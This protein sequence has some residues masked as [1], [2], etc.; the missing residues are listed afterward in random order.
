MAPLDEILQETGMEYGSITPVGLPNSWRIL[1]DSRL[2][3]REKIIVGGGKQISKLLVPTVAL[4]D[5][6]N[7][8]VV[9]GLA[10]PLLG[11]E[12]SK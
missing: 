2:M 7:A 5:L 8:E 11:S 10:S 12:A 9:E 3:D 1:I 6:S 4:K